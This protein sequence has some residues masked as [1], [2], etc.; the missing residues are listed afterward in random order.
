[1]V[2]QRIVGHPQELLRHDSQV[3]IAEGLRDREGLLARRDRAGMVPHLPQVAAHKGGDPPPPRLVAEGLGEGGRL[4][5][6]GEHQP[7]FAECLEDESSGGLSWAAVV[8]VEAAYLG[9]RGQVSADFAFDEAEDEQGQ[10][11]HGDQGGDPTAQVG[12]NPK[13]PDLQQFLI[14]QVHVAKIIGW[15]KDE[16]P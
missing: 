8:D 6:V 7:E 11:D 1:M 5:E 2:T 15:K 10:A 3:H 4:A 13:L 9:V 16:T 14:P 12:P